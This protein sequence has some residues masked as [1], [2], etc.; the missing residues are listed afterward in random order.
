MQHWISSY[1][2]STLHF[3]CK[4]IRKENNTKGGMKPTLRQL[5]TSVLVI[6]AHA[7]WEGGL[8]MVQGFQWERDAVVVQ[9]RMR[10]LDLHN[11][12]GYRREREW[13]GGIQMV[14]RVQFIAKWGMRIWMTGRWG[15]KL[16]TNFAT[17]FLFASVIIGMIISVFFL[18]D[19]FLS[20]SSSC[21]SSLYT[22][23]LCLSLPKTIDIVQL[24]HLHVLSIA[25][26]VQLFILNQQ[27]IQICQNGFNNLHMFLLVMFIGRNCYCHMGWMWM[28]NKSQ[29]ANRLKTVKLVPAKFSKT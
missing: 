24:S 1:Y 27:Q 18:F 9:D 23:L 10:T 22:T 25:T 28:L 2:Y 7:K 29:I 8:K 15:Y 20:F 14:W 4:K 12:L 17:R 19:S 16:W 3:F 6:K 13:E 26:P 11:I 5:N 21:I